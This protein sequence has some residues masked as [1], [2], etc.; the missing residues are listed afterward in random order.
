MAT[1]DTNFDNIR[2]AIGE[3]YDN[4]EITPKQYNKDID[5][6]Y[7]IV[8]KCEEYGDGGKEFPEEF[9]HDIPSKLVGKL[10]KLME[11]YEE[12]L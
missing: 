11:K 3:S 2:N 6:L 12:Y 8:N 7:N 9:S 10:Y 4:Q 5:K 1:L